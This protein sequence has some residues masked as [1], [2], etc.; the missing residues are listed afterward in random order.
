M[1][2]PFGNAS[3]R[4]TEAEFRIANHLEQDPSAKGYGAS[5]LYRDMETLGAEPALTSDQVQSFLDSFHT[6]VKLSHPW[7][8]KNPL[9]A[10][11]QLRNMGISLAHDAIVMGD[12]ATAYHA[13]DYADNPITGYP[14]DAQAIKDRVF[15]QWDE[16][17][18]A[19]GPTLT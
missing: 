8:S 2:V 13:A 17:V 16:W 19:L 7:R 9:Y 6:L 10:T 1:S 12:L 5:E 3:R 4:Y 18:D 11:R 15:A 14:V